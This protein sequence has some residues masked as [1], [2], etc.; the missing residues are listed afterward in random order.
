MRFETSG[1]AGA[2]SS[3]AAV[4][5][6]YDAVFG[7]LSSEEEWIEAM[8]AR[9]AGRRGHR[10]VCAFDGEAVVG[11]AWG[12]VGE[13][14]QDWSDAA[15]DALGPELAERWVGG[16]F[17]FVELGVHPERRRHGIGRR[18]H[19]LLLEGVRG[20]CLLSTS[21]DDA[22]PAVRLYETSGWRTLGPLSPGRRIM[23][24]RA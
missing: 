1:G 19:D 24:L 16:H 12:Y 15:A 14:G 20:S 4:W 2:L 18:L 5:R 10:L 11:F 23:A 6:C 13:R 21:D 9:H 7:D 22:D 17:E 8:F 3:A